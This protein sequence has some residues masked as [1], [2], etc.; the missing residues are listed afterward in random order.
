LFSR[1]EFGKGDV[2]RL[3]FML[4]RSMDGRDFNS[5]CSLIIS[6]IPRFFEFGVIYH[7][8]Y[9]TASFGVFLSFLC[10]FFFSFLFLA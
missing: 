8:M 2:W 1:N 7:V 9:R 6:C 10:S 4:I 5:N 3:V